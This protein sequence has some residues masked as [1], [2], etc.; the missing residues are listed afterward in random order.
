MLRS[1]TMTV[2]RTAST[3]QPIH[4]SFVSISVL[5]STIAV[6]PNK[7]QGLLNHRQIL[8]HQRR[9]GDAHRVV[10]VPVAVASYEPS[11]QLA[12]HPR[13]ALEHVVPVHPTGD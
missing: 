12:Q 11:A 5:S 7:L 3:S 13:D 2:I 9:G 6:E 4:T 1:E 8:P 10:H